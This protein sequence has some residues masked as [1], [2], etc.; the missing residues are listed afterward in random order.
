MRRLRRKTHENAQK[1]TK[2]HENARVA[3]C[4]RVR[5]IDFL[6]AVNLCGDVRFPNTEKGRE[7]NKL[8]KG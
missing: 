1:R 2:T 4:V 8:A 3:G 5:C 6:A 7:K